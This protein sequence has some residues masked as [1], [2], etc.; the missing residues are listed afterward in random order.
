MKIH[1][2]WLDMFTL[3][4]Q[5]NT[6]VHCDIDDDELCD[7]NNEDIFEEEQKIHIN[8]YNGVKHIIFET[9]I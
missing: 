2:R 9:N 3:S 7:H 1:P 5:T 8:K 6:N 4:M